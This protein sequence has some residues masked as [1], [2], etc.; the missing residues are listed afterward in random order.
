MT[1]QI[2]M[3]SLTL[4]VSVVITIL[5]IR[6]RKELVSIN[7]ELSVLKE[8]RSSELS[9][10]YCSYVEIWK[11]LSDLQLYLNADL[12]K[13]IATDGFDA[14]FPRLFVFYNE[15]RK[16]TIHLAEEQFDFVKRMW[17]E[18]IIAETSRIATAVINKLPR[19]SEEFVYQNLSDQDLRFI[20]SELNKFIHNNEKFMDEI[21]RQF[22]PLMQIELRK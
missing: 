22:R 6:S 13:N 1:I 14:N 2:F 18:Y 10:I 20:R 9:S 12:K 11:I 5:Q 3:T 21:R 15:Y 4:L 17:D 16:Q 7:N 8:Y 19:P